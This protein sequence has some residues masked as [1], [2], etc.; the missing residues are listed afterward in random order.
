M[1]TLLQ[2]DRPH[3]ARAEKPGPELFEQTMPRS[4][5]H[6]AAV[7]EV[8]LTGWQATEDIQ[9]LGAQWSRG[10]SYYGR[11][12]GRWHDPMLL[13][14]TIRQAC[15]LLAHE[16]LD[17]PMDF[18]FLTESTAF[19]VTEEGVRLSRP[20]RPAHVVLHMRLGDVKRRAGVVSSFGYD[21]VAHRDGVPFGTGRLSG[22]CASPA[23]YRRLRG[24]RLGA[25]P[26]RTTVE[27]VEHGLVGRD[28]EFDVVIGASADAGVHALRVD[29]EHPVL[30]D[31]PVDHVP[32]MV[33]M[34][35]ARQAALLAV[36]APQSLLVSCETHFKRYVEFHIP[37]LVSADRPTR[38]NDGRCTLT[39]RFHQGGTEVGTCKVSLIAPSG[40]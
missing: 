33:L 26:P 7:S 4:L 31:H 23:V 5:V 1:S 13:A 25:Q 30:F 32:G 24:D 37:C 20:C 34:E 6:R 3:C 14:E 10:H 19:A 2:A 38:D 28:C 15:L 16:A 35:A 21:V 39:V 17:V 9:Y 40:S 36:G 12:D 11:V 29:A 27:P 18:S 22:K 8:L